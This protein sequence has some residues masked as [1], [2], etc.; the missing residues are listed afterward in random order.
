MDTKQKLILEKLVK[1]AQSQQK[2]LNKLAQIAN[3]QQDV[4]TE[5][6]AQADVPKTIEY[7][8][9]AVQLAGVN[10]S[11]PISGLTA[12]VTATPGHDG[13]FTIIVDGFPPVKLN[14]PKDVQRDNALKMAFK[15]TFDAQLSA[16]GKAALLNNLAIMYN[17]K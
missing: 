9:G 4:R 16:Q 11:P 12:K 6:S 1:L 8:K 3:V 13:G 10:T 7:L 15:K 17:N 5:Q 2:V 14:D